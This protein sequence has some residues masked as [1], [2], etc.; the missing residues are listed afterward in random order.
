MVNPRKVKEVEEL[1]K[2]IE[3]YPVVGIVNMYGMPARPLQEIRKMLRGKAVIRMSKKTLM[4]LAL[5][6]STKKG[7]EKLEEYMEG[8]PA[9]IFSKIDAFMLYKLLQKEKTPMPA[10]AG[11][12]AP[13]DVIVKAGPTPI[14]A[15][16]AIGQFNRLKIPVMVQDGK[17]HVRQDTVVIRK[18]EV[19]SEELANLL[20]KLGIEPMEMT[21]NLI[22]AW[23]DGIIFTKDVLA[24][25]EE[26]YKEKLLQAFQNALKLSVEIV[27]PTKHNIE[28]LLTKAFTN[29]KT[30]GLEAGIIDKGVIEDLIKKA[31]LQAKNLEDVAKV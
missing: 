3:E 1:K 15:G 29:A 27:Y 28:M 7:V 12:V 23:Q 19:F 20:G 14:P 2:L 6:G 31:Y 25:D 5:K 11:D 22:A 9:F 13:K 18:G 26:E 4:K 17:I 30:L 16:P 10:K 24:V 21:L 8:Q